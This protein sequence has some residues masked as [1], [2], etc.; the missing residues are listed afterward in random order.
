MKQV[1]K[2]NSIVYLD[3]GSNLGGDTAVKDLCDLMKVQRDASIEV[4]D[5][6]KMKM[7]EKSVNVVRD[8]LI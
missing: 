2:Q 4:I 3:I 6:S 5:I 7:S 8:A 1:K